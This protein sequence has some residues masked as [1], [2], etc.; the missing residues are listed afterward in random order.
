MKVKSNK[1]S[2]PFP[3]QWWEKPAVSVLFTVFFIIAD[4][5]MKYVSI[6]N[7][8]DTDSITGQLKL[9][10]M[11]ATIVILIDLGPE[12]MGSFLGRLFHVEKRFLKAVMICLAAAIFALYV[13]T[14]PLTFQ[15]G[16]VDA[17]ENTISKE[18]PQT[19]I[20][21]SMLQEE[22]SEVSEE[23]ASDDLNEQ[24]L[25]AN[26][27]VVHTTNF[28]LILTPIVTSVF[29]FVL[30]LATAPAKK[31]IHLYDEIVICQQRRDALLAEKMEL[32]KRPIV[33]KMIESDQW[34]KEAMK[35]EI[36]LYLSDWQKE[37]MLPCVKRLKNPR[38]TTRML[39]DPSINQF[40][41]N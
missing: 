3:L 15:S 25:E 19:D 7:G 12:V 16:D 38:M 13:V 18:E 33:E 14:I 22:Q 1:S 10:F 9:A 31:K 34:S 30:G 26:Q 41:F 37:I 27:K 35:A 21:T 23:N 8:F 2:Y 29:L 20:Y 28:L 39:A 40:E 6:E 11:A 24:L 17:L 4:M 5:C 32:E 36:Q